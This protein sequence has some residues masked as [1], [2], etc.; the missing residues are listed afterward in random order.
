MNLPQSFLDSINSYFNSHPEI[1]KT[2]FFESFDLESERGIRLNRLKIKPSD[3]IRMV[4]LVRRGSKISN[5]ADEPE[6]QK[7]L[8]D[9]IPWNPSGYYIS[10][11]VSG[12]D[13]LFHAGAIY[14]QEPSAMLPARVLMAEE[15]DYI[16]DMCAAPGGKATAIAEQ[17][18]PDG[19]LVANEI[20]NQRAKAL[21]RNIERFGITNA[22]ILNENPS[23][24]KN[25]FTSFF[26]KILIDAPCSGEGMFRRD[27]NAT[28]SWLKYGPNSTAQIQEEILEYADAMLKPGG[29]IVY[30]T[31]T[32]SEI[33]NEKM[34]S[35][36]IEKHQ[37]YVVVDLSSQIPSVWHNAS[38][39]LPGSMR[40]WPHLHRGDGHFCVRLEKT[41]CR[42]S[43]ESDNH[44]LS[45]EIHARRGKERDPGSTR[46]TKSQHEMREAY[47]EFMKDL[48]QES[49][50]RIFSDRSQRDFK[51]FGEGFRIHNQ[52]V[53]LYRQLKI[54]KLGL[55]PGDIKKTTNGLY[56]NPSHSLALT[57]SQNMI[58]TSRFLNM[59]YDDTRLL[60]YLK[61]ETLF[62]S[63]SE[64]EYLDDKCYLVV[65]VEG[66]PLGFVQHQN[67]MLKNLYPQ[68]WRVL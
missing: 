58:R 37:E 44:S 55:F 64:K 5:Q 21:M 19:L 12:N 41:K 34:I 42:C 46:L 32:F 40:I 29:V 38:G 23:N 10:G 62:L 50:Y 67:G 14:I 22:V 35:S 24:L 25:A 9:P 15:G 48:L 36:F 43:A 18:G 3:D 61:G 49:E 65:A 6:K 54:V 51:I 26:D 28:A 63:D 68:G 13:P 31:C 1:P 27:P 7:L 33:E 52:P 20:S 16:L 56:F 66:L 17:I 11:A 4:S 39:T 53:D 60:R 57:L 45:N 30:S 47:L 59:D 2:G 8:L